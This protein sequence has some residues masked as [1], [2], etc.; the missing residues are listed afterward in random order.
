[1]DVTLVSMP[2]AE[3]PRPSIA[4]GLLRAA[5]DGSG[6]RSQVVYANFGFAETVGLTAYQAI[7]STPPD[8]LLGEWCFSGGLTDAEPEEDDEFLD[9]ILEVRCSGFPETLEER[10]ALMRGMRARAPDY[11]DRVAH[12]I[13]EDRP[14][15]VGCS[16]VFQQHCASLALL[17]RIRQLS[18]DT[19]TLMGGANCEGEMG[20]E[21]LRSFPWVDCVVSGEADGFFSGLCR[22][23]LDEGPRP[24]PSKLPFG[25][26]TQ[27]QVAT[28]ESHGGSPPRNVVR[29]LDRLPTPR[30]DDYFSMLAASRL[31]PYVRPGLLAE[32]SRGCWW[33]E[34]SHCTFCGLNGTGMAYRSKSP[35]RVLTELGELAL[36]YGLRNIQFVDNI[37]DMSHIK[38]VL[39]ELAQASPKYALFYETKANLKRAQVRQLAE[40]GV[41]WIQPG[42]E[43]L[44]DRALKLLG[45]G[46]SAVMNL[47]LLKWTRE[48]GI[49]PSWNFLSG[50]PGEEDAWYS[51]MADW[52]PSITHL[53]PPSGVTR[54]RFDRFSPYYM[55]P[56]DYGLE[57]RPSRAYRYVYPLSGPSLERLAYYFEDAGENGHVHRCM[58][59]RPGVQR[60]QRTVEQWKDLWNQSPPVLQVRQVPSGLHVADSRPATAAGR[61]SLGR[62]EAAVF[63]FCD[64]A[65]PRSLLAK[66]LPGHEEAVE[67]LLTLRLLLQL[68]GKLLSIGTDSL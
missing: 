29:D 16:S 42:I 47:Q 32:S 62:R 36:R 49:H 37:L 44:D 9:M 31:S 56:R 40:A 22:I 11:I 4:L 13:L 61:Y 51:E 59:F 30:Y 8:H 10:K 46:N 41:R 12:S 38:T 25:V 27:D 60:L 55:R 20:L 24:Q 58:Q 5:L 45:K 3:L 23:L 67:T 21:T 19:V 28:L 63:R 6:L 18:P 66:K 7:H 64:S 1:M 57:L 43:S 14:R 48:Y 34:R 39:P 68:N 52:L 50:A 26:M 53:Q 33:G 15:I 35:Q 54:I 65:R 17:R 2:F